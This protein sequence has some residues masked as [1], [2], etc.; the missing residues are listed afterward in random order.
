VHAPAQPLAAATGA[1]AEAHTITVR[2]PANRQRPRV[3]MAHDAA[4]RERAGCRRVG[5]RGGYESELLRGLPRRAAPRVRT[6]AATRPWPVPTTVRR[7]PTC[8]VGSHGRA[9]RTLFVW[10][11]SH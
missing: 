11:I 4:E 8:R 1:E 6:A 10:I 5:E 3:R 9:I 7:Q 2:S